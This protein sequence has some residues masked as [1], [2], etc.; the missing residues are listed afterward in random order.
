MTDHA[1]RDQAATLVDFEEDTDELRHQVL[2]DE[3][4]TD[5]EFAHG[6]AQVRRRQTLL[7]KGRGAVTAQ[8]KAMFASEP[9][10]TK[11][12]AVVLPLHR[13]GRTPTEIGRHL[14][15]SSQAVHGHLTLS[16]IHI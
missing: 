6:L 7:R 9:G 4:Q 3:T 11:Q 2:T 5:E 16:L 13:R 1:K 8:P 10:L 12:Q 15:I 14:G